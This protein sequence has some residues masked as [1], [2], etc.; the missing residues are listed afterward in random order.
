MTSESKCGLCGEPM[1]EGEEMFKYHGYSGPCPK[2]ALKK[3]STGHEYDVMI[4]G[5]VGPDVWD[6]EIVVTEVDI[7][8]AAKAAKGRADDM[9]G[10]VV[11]LQQAI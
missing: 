10:Y 9:G 6:R 5:G 7:V 3:S 1:P 11:S 8:D 4:Q 2:P